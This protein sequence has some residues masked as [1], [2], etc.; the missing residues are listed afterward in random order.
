MS[1]RAL[2]C[3][4]SADGRNWVLEASAEAPDV[5]IVVD[6][7]VHLT[8]S[9]TALQMLAR[10]ALAALGVRPLNAGRRW[11]TEADDALRQAYASGPSPE[12]LADQF[13]RTVPA[14]KARLAHLGLIEDDGS[15]RR[16]IAR[17]PADAQA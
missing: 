10:Q 5:E 11:S 1:E 13:G 9:R 7:R 3:S 16:Y 17:V 4:W 8:C 12:D 14:I 15:Y 2:S 6:D